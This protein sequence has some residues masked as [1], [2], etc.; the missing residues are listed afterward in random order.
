[1]FA[2]TIR[3]AYSFSQVQLMFFSVHLSAVKAVILELGA[4]IFFC[5]VFCLKL[6]ACWKHEKLDILFFS[7][8]CIIIFMP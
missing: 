5:N 1:V 7:T 4:V 3:F 8:M 6:K 2:A